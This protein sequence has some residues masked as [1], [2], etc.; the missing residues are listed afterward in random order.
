VRSKLDR[1]SVC[2]DVEV[3]Q[4]LAMAELY[5]SLREDMHTSRSDIVPVAPQTPV[6]DNPLCS[7]TAELPPMPD[8]QHFLWSGNVSVHGIQW[9]LCILF[10]KYF[11]SGE[12][13]DVSVALKSNIRDTGHQSCQVRLTLR[14][15]NVDPTQDWTI[16]ETGIF[17]PNSCN[18]YGWT[19]PMKYTDLADINNGWL[20]QERGRH[21]LI[22]VSCEFTAE[23]PQPTCNVV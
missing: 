19:L 17:R 14:F 6:S 22:K 23:P 1:P 3:R 8:V 11:N 13:D 7:V 9:E 21:A 12:R 18:S 16:S 2:S 5:D 15:L 10:G 20:H 4:F